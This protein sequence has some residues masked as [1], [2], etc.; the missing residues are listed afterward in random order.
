L[1][2]IQ[3]RH[4]LHHAQADF[5]YC[6]NKLHHHG[7][8]LGPGS[9]FLLEVSGSIPSDVNLGGLVWLLQKKKI[10]PSLGGLVW[11]LQKKKFHHPIK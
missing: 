10:P 11:L 6:I 5:Y 3:V 9:V 1:G 8:G 4:V 7:I 2:P